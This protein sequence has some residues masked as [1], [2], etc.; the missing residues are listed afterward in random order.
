MVNIFLAILNDAYIA[1][2]EEFD[3]EAVNDG[4]PPMTIRQHIQWLR[5]YLRQRELDQKIEKLRKQQRR[6]EIIE[7][8]EIRKRE[9][10]RQKTLKTLGMAANIMEQAN[11]AANSNS[12]NRSANGLLSEN[13]S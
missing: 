9:E 13:S 4:P 8:R 1:V 12:V 5:S 3:K 7:K 11:H 10:A 6:A 2:K